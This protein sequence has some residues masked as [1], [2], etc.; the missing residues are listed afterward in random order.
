LQGF[1]IGGLIGDASPVHHAIPVEASYSRRAVTV[2]P[3]VH[4]ESIAKSSL[5]A[6]DLTVVCF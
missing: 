1:P 5:I 4:A 2:I 6:A 3:S